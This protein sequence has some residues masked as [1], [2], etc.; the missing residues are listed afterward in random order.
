LQQVGAGPEVWW[1]ADHP[2]APRP[3]LEAPTA[4]PRWRRRLAVWP[5]A[6]SAFLI[7]GNADLHGIAL[8]PV[9]RAAELAGLGL[10]QVTLSGHR[11]TADNDIYAA[12]ELEGAR[13]LL[14]FDAGA[15]QARIQQLPWIKRA[16]IE[17]IVPDRIDVRVTERVPFAVWREGE[18]SWLVDR[19]GRR[20]Q[21][22]PADVMPGLPRVSGAG[23]AEEAAALYALLG[24]FPQVARKL[25]VAERIGDR[26]WT[27]HL[28]GGAGVELPASG[29]AE[30]LS[31]LARMLESGLGGAG[32]IDLRAPARVLVQGLDAATAERG[33]AAPAGR[34]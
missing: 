16:S 29:E 23:A 18:R 14:T 3:V 21:I 2:P 13:T 8:A 4:A 12:L 9:E 20:L 26:R 31:R 25:E 24:D 1:R 22:A 7:L 15:A 32:R 5:L 28:K 34:T 30:A 11:F 19:A 6:A 10:Q 17:R 27:L 33:P